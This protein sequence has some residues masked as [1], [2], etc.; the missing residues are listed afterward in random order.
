MLAF[1]EV[2]TAWKKLHAGKEIRVMGLVE[3]N[4]VL[5]QALHYCLG[6]CHPRRRNIALPSIA[7][8]PYH[9][10]GLAPCLKKK[11]KVLRVLGP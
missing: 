4:G 7:Q 8:A 10:S 5:P 6:P 2:K 1:P 11:K 9:S 3:W